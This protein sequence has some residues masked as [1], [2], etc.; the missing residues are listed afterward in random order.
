MEMHIVL[1]SDVLLMVS[2]TESNPQV[3]EMVFIMRPR[4]GL[5]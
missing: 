5:L 1:D 3:S 4:Q 2:E